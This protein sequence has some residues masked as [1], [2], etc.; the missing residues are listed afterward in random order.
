RWAKERGCARYDWWGIPD[1]SEPEFDSL[2]E[3]LYRFKQG[4]G[5]KMVTFVGSYDYILRPT[6]YRLYNRLIR[7]RRRPATG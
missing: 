3:G 1:T 6:I 4:F 2:P 5:G 7:S